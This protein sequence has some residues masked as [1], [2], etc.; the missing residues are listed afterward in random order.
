MKKSFVHSLRSCVAVLGVFFFS[1]AGFGEG[2]LGLI[3]SFHGQVE[4]TRQGAS[5]TVTVGLPILLNDI[6]ETKA[7]GSARLV[8]ADRNVFVLDGNSHFV[9]SAYQAQTA[10]QSANVLIKAKGRIHAEIKAHYDDAKST[11]RMQLASAVVGVRGTEFL[12]ESSSSATKITTLEG[13]VVVGS[14]LQDNNSITNPVRVAKGFQFS[15][16][17][18]Q[19]SIP[20]AK[21]LSEGEMK[22]VLSQIQN[23]RNQ[24]SG[25]A[26][27]AGPRPGNGSSKS[28]GPGPGPGGPPP[29]PVPGAGAPPPQPPQ[30]P[31]P[32]PPTA[33]PALPAAVPAPTAP[34]APR[35]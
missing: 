28:A 11:F 21:H 13:L 20:V 6:I 17:D 26:P 12:A 33:P 29:G 16:T 9:V 23:M 14:S 15:H 2:P 35:H 31:P 7:D 10:D 19:S 3:Q 18:S 32:P 34:P 22:G 8:M 27:E 24:L 5:K 25:K 4:L 30:G 1:Q